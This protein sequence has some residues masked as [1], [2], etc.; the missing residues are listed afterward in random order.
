[1]PTFMY[2]IK[3]SADLLSI[4]ITYMFACLFALDRAGLKLSIWLGVCGT[5]KQ[6]QGFTLAKQ[7]LHHP[8]Y[9][10][11]HSLIFLL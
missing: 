5:G 10:P 7:A 9:S 6:T 4:F 2:S 1:M 3:L 8:S 11:K